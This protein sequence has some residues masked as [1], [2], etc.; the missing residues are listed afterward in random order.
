MNKKLFFKLIC[1]LL[2]SIKLPV[3][4]QSPSQECFE[5]IEFQ[6][7]FLALNTSYD[8]ELANW[9]K[10]NFDM[11][12]VKEFA[13]SNGESFGIILKKDEQ[14]IEIIHSKSTSEADI[15][16]GHV[17]SSGHAGFQ[18]GGIFTE[19]DLQDLQRCLKAA[20][21]SA[22]RIYHDRELKLKLLHLIDPEGNQF[23]IISPE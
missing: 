23:E 22:G 2:L 14:I 1:L 21:I 10:S 12:T 7:G 11:E 8:S 5:N 3:W 20:G 18:K 17:Q 9:Y 15:S 13:S 16:Q 4:A 19:S 6:K